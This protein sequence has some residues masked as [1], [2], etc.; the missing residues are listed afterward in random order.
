ME[1][2]DRIL[3][4]IVSIRINYIVFPK[5]IARKMPIYSSWHVKWSGVKRGSFV[6][7]SDQIYKGMIQIGFDRIAKGLLGGKKSIVLIEGNGQIVIKGKEDLSQGISI[8]VADNAQLIIGRGLYSNGYCSIRCRKK[9]TIG[10]DNMW[11]WNVT[12]MDTD[13]H[14]IYDKD[15]HII[16]EYKDIFIGDN[17][18]LGAYSKILKGALIP[19]GCVIGM[20]SIVTKSIESKNAILAGTPAKVVKEYI[21]WDRGDFPNE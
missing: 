15:R 10:N 9:I 8:L 18:W 14:P 11:G 19:D 20:S 3:N 4:K 17:V 2:I 5:E 7:D 13:G 16:N 12:V 6:L 21:T 1:I